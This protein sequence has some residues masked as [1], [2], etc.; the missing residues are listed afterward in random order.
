V[1]TKP[2]ITPRENSSDSETFED[3]NDRARA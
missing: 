1:T 3:R 2:K